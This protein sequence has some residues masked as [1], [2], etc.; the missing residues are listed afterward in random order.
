VTNSKTSFLRV[1]AVL[2]A[3]ATPILPATA[4][5]G[6]AAAEAA[7]AVEADPAFFAMIGRSV[8][9]SRVVA[10]SKWLRAASLPAGDG[11]AAADLPLFA[12][13]RDTGT[14]GSPKYEAS[15]VVLD[16]V[17]ERYGTVRIE[18]AH[19]VLTPS[20]DGRSCAFQVAGSPFGGETVLEAS[21]SITWA[22][23]PLG[24]DELDVSF[25]LDHAPVEALRAAFPGRFDPSFVGLL[26][27][28]GKASG[29][30]GETTTEDVPATPLRGQFEAGL[31]WTILGRTAPLSVVSSFS[32]DDRLMRLSAATMKWQNFQLGLQGWL[33]PQPKGKFELKAKFADID[34]L[35]VATEWTV[36]EPWRPVAT[37]SGTVTFAGTPGESQLRYEASAPQLEVPALGGN[38]IRVTAPT[39][40]GNVLAINTDVSASVKGTSLRVGDLD[41]GSVP[42]GIQWWRERVS[43]TSAGITLWGGKFDNSAS[44]KPESHPEFGISGRLAKAE[45][46]TMLAAVA[47]SLGLD[48]SGAAS[49]SWSF[50]Q[51]AS[52]NPLWTVHASLLSGRLGNLDLF[53][54]VYDAL[55]AADASLATADAST[56]LP[57]PRKGDGTRVDKLFFEIARNGEHYDLGGLSLAG[58][59]FRFDADGNWSKQ[60]GLRLDGTV[61]LPQ[62]FAA[63]LT[64]TAPWLSSLVSPVGV[65][66]VPVAIGGTSAAPTVALTPAYVAML[67]SARRGEAVTPPQAKDPR[68]VG[69]DNLG[70]IAGD[71]KS[72]DYE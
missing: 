70:P 47:P 23:G 10:L 17:T 52:R 67:A 65:L 20:P 72:T 31:D 61:A 37:I 22:T 2:L 26:G 28:R 5:P 16:V 62:A 12:V 3:L 29:V 38:T 49:L 21:G 71:P 43:A 69:A 64:A 32:L 48:A 15:A 55:V 27:I 42:V 8:P 60:D 33:D 53:A 59:E 9:A 54:R 24:G 51:D 11:A 13:L 57:K 30:V 66:V 46:A 40:L 44:Y 36:P 7:A 56:L 58:E 35:K 50:G 45:A 63:K 14:P 19:V 6:P 68:H 18:K 41:F 34:T 39:I 25:R 1:T 4:A